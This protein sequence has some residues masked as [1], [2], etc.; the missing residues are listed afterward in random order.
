MITN[1]L[2]VIGAGL[3]FLFIFLSGIW[4]SRSG[5]PYSVVILS[6]HEF[7]SLAAAALYCEVCGAYVGEPD[8]A[9]SPKNQV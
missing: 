9:G 6:I 1:Q 2:R 8:Y 4:L 3:F 5:K 7:I